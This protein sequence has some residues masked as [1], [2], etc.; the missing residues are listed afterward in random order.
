MIGEARVTTLVTDHNHEW[1]TSAAEHKG[2]T[3]A[4]ISADIEAD[5]ARWAR[6]GIRRPE[7]MKLVAMALRV[8]FLT[9]DVKT[10][11]SAGK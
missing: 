1:H 3:P 6:G 10:K 4:D 11:V 7:I 8:D 5:I 9:T 2:A